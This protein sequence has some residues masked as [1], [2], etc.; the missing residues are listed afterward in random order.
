MGKKFFWALNTRWF[1]KDKQTLVINSFCI[2][3]VILKVFP[4][5]YYESV[6][7]ITKNDAVRKFTM[8]QINE[9]D[10]LWDFLIQNKVL[11]SDMVDT[12]YLFENQWRCSYVDEELTNKL[13]SDQE[14]L[15]RYMD[16]V[17]NRNPVE[18]YT[19]KEIILE[20]SHKNI[21][22]EISLRKSVRVFDKKKKIS[23]EQISSLLQVISY[24]DGNSHTRSYYPSAG[25]LYPIDIYLYIKEN[26]IDNVEEGLYYYNP[27]KHVLEKIQNKIDVLSIHV[28]SSK[29]MYAQSA[30]S[31]FFIFDSEVSLPKYLGRAYYYAIIDAGIISQTLALQAECLGLGSCIVGN[32]DYSKLKTHMKIQGKD[33]FLFAMEYGIK[34]LSDKNERT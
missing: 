8:V 1:I 6:Q 28:G 4:D 29:E 19:L 31:M 33:K 34:N 22:K 27:N 2:T 11:V 25:A 12:E 13:R 18:G 3:G 7:G 10:K 30:F 9:I 17:S 15:L 14:Y 23:E 5:F 32:S 20:E 26:R 16:E 24:R 21:L